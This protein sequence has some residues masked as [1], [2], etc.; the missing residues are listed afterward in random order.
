MKP[1]K[2]PTGKKTAENLKQLYK[3]PKHQPINII[4]SFETRLL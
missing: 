1:L 4:V 2:I 3:I